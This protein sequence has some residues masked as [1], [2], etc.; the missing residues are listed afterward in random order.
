VNVLPDSTDRLGEGIDLLLKEEPGDWI[1]ATPWQLKALLILVAL[2]LVIWTYRRLVRAIKRMRKPRL[3]PKL[4]KYGAGYGEPSEAVLKRRRA[5]AAKILAT[6]STSD[7]KGYELIEQIEAVYVDGFRRPEDAL[8]GLKAVA[9]MKGANAV[10]NV[11]HEHG[12]SGKCSATGDAV[13][14]ARHGEEKSATPGDSHAAASPEANEPTASEQVP[15]EST[16]TQ[17]EDTPPSS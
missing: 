2:L 9:A 3:H 15:R 8:E 5:E 11:R 7:I 4:Q 6:S 12:P 1:D 16:R 14:V 10:T 13:I 17:Q